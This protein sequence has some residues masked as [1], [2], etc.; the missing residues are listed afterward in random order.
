MPQCDDC[1]FYR[2]RS[3][4]T[5]GQGQGVQ[6]VGE[7]RYSDPVAQGQNGVWPRIKPDDWCGKWEAIAAQREDRA[8]GE[9]PL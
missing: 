1:N 5:V 3:Y 2:L 8:L 4:G 9:I 6:T 7:C